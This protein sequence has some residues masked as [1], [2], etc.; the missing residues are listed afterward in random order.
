MKIEL[1]LL[2]DCLLI[3]LTKHPSLLYQPMARDEL[4]LNVQSN[5]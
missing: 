1:N 2:P 3:P 5:I 4:R